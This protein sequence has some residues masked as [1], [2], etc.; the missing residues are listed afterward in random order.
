MDA[1]RLRR[2]PGARA[3]A[4]AR[5]RRARR[6]SRPRSPPCGRRSPPDGMRAARSIAAVDSHTEGMPTRVVT[7]GVAPI[8]GATM[9]ERRDALRGRT[10]RPAAAADARAARPRRDVGGDPAARRRAPD[11]DWGVLFIEVCGLP[12]D[13]R[14][15][16]DRRRHRAGR[17]RDGRGA[18]ARD[19][20]AARHAGRARRGAGGRAG[21]PR[22][23]RSR[24]ATSRRFLHARDVAVDVP[25]LG[26]V[27]YDMAF[28]GNFYA[29]LP[30]ASVG[31]EVDP[32]RAGELIEAGARDHRRDRRRRP[33][34]ASGRRADRGLPPRRPPRAGTRRRR[35]GRGATAIHPGWLDRSPCGTGTSARMA[36][37]H[38]RGELA[39]GAAFVNESMIGTR[40]TGRLVAETTRSAGGPRSC[41]RS[42]A[43]RGSP[44]WASTCSTPTTPSRPA[45]RC[46]PTSRWSAPASSAPRSHAS[47]PCAASP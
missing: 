27:T 1:A 46:E 28:G 44:G 43:A 6:P 12:A 39:L 8:P 42:P 2:R 5:R 31:L 29:L 23:A 34:G 16:D 45:S 33:P 30:A 26:R 20:R 24:C 21:R 35:R 3:A 22:D 4:G 47:W 40:F 38:A 19:R 14:A 13:V 9:L 25:G 11:A 37:L 17:D 18:R 10:G 15:R 41:R 32:A 36:Q 7:G